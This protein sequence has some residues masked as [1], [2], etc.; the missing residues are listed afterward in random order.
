MPG[1]YVVQKYGGDYSMQGSG[2]VWLSDV[3]CNGR[4]SWVGS[5]R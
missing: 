4:E 3:H 5:C 1:G 2:K